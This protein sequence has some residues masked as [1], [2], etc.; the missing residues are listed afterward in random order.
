MKL[1]VSVIKKTNCPK[2]NGEGVISHFQHVKGGECFKCG[3]TG[4]GP[5]EY[6]ERPMTD[7]EVLAGLAAVGFPV[8]DVEPIPT[9][10]WLADIFA[11]MELKTQ[12][13]IG[14]RLLLEAI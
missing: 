14:A 1:T 4:N 2:C 13:M 12:S 10:D 6:T 8:I 3:G 11:A 9:S 7:D 5:L